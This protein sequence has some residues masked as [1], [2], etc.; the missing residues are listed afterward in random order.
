M[1]ANYGN[2]KS[3]AEEESIDRRFSGIFDVFANAGG[4]PKN[5]GS[6][7]GETIDKVLFHGFD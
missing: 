6:V 5:G 7:D 2:T 1:T 4:L 3:I